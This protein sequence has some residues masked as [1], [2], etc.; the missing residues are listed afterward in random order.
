MAQFQLF[1][2]NY[3]KDAMEVYENLRCWLADRDVGLVLAQYTAEDEVIE[4]AKNADICLAYRFKVTRKAIASLPRLKLLMASGSG[5]DHID[6]Q[7]ATDHGVVV[8]NAATHNIEDV[9]EHTLALILTC[10]QKICFLDSAVQQGN[11]SCALLAQPIHRMRGQALG[12]IG[13]GK[14]GQA[15]AWR[16]NGLGFRVLAYDPYVPDNEIKKAGVKPVGLEE[17]LQRSDFVS[18]HLRLNEETRHILS[19]KQLRA[20]KST[21]Y[22]INTSRGGVIDEAALI[23]ALKEGWI[24]GAGLDVLE[25]EPPNQDN[26]LL[27]LK[28][29][30]VTGH[31]AASTVEAEQDWLE[32]WKKIIEDFLAGWW[33]INVVNSEVQPKVSLRKRPE[34]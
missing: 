20:M 13:L 16:A 27:T 32:E 22:V 1:A 11:W 14:I 29:V 31:S 7:A 18:L 15:V 33:P 5:Y 8:T 12:I 17:L 2:A 3:N 25:Q 6:V 23:R 9:A 30:V 28:N 4:R 24:A 19:E 26:P 21:A 10:G 34:R